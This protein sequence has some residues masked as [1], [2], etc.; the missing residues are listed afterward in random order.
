MANEMN[1]IDIRDFPIAGSLEQDDYVVVSLFDG[2]SARTRV[3][4]IRE[5]VLYGMK[6]SIKEDGYWYVGDEPTGVL[7]KGP[8]PLFRKVDGGVEYKYD[9][10]D[11]ASWRPLLTFH[12]LRLRYE[13]LT[14]AQVYELRMRFED[15]TP[16][17]QDVLRLK[18]EDLTEEQIEELQKPAADAVE[19]LKKEEEQWKA[20]EELRV[21]REE[22]RVKNEE[23][24]KKAEEERVASNNA[25]T[26]AEFKRQQ[27]ETERIHNDN[28][29]RQAEAERV[30]SEASRQRAE[31]SREEMEKLRQQWYE[32]ASKQWGNQTL[33]LEVDDNGDINVI[34]GGV[35][36]GFRQGYVADNG[37]VVLEF[38][39]W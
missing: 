38:Y 39:F 33:A 1:N 32:E 37:D 15:L 25:W 7:A 18:F 10:E 21:K 23:D 4:I 27:A 30:A 16:A 12:D 22:E 20:N 34:T 9:N 36:T 11:D 8:T 29:V 3:G 35:D 13:D 5:S 31:L 6:P 14:P 26:E 2:R 28:A 17:Q 24:R 19:E